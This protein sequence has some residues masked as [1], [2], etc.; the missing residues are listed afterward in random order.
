MRSR[1]RLSC[2]ISLFKC[3]FF[4]LLKDIS[5]GSYKPTPEGGKVLY[6]PDAE[7]DLDEEDPDDDLLI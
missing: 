7:D 5:F 2:T 1:C 3:G 6:H 4:S